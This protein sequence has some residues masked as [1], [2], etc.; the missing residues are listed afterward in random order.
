MR[1]S[2][3]TLSRELARNTGQR[4]YRYQQADRKAKQRHVEKPKAI[5]LTTALAGSIDV[6]LEELWSPEQNSGRLKK[7]VSA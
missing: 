1:R 7:P 3:S 4:G 5:K 2:Q 6:M